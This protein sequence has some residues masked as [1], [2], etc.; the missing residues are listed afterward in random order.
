MVLMKK[1]M[2]IVKMMEIVRSTRKP[3]SWGHNADVD[4]EDEDGE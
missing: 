3:W 4:E 1:M 2:I